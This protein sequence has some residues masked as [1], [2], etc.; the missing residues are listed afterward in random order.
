[1]VKPAVFDA[2]HIVSSGLWTLWGIALNVYESITCICRNSWQII[3]TSST[4]FSFASLLNSHYSYIQEHLKLSTSICLFLCF[5]MMYQ[6]CKKKNC[7]ELI[8]NPR[9]YVYIAYIFYSKDWIKIVLNIQ[10]T[11][12]VIIIT[13]VIITLKILHLGIQI[14]QMWKLIFVKTVLMIN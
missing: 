4:V 6:S 9:I 5:L 1:M 10:L 11:I 14:K 3:N 8:S 2:F 7:H 12:K 13:I